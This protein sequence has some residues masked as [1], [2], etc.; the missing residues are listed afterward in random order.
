MWVGRHRFAV[1]ALGDRSQAS[2]QERPGPG[3][4]GAIE[5]GVPEGAFD[6]VGQGLD[7]GLGQSDRAP[8]RDPRVRLEPAARPKRG[9]DPDDPIDRPIQIRLSENGQGRQLGGQGTITALDQPQRGV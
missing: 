9:R 6:R 7:L 3:F 4:L 1:L 5:A 8:A 2:G